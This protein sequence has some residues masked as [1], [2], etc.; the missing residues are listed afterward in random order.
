MIAEYEARLQR[1]RDSHEKVVNENVKLNAELRATERELSE[2]KS[3]SRKQ[4]LELTACSDKIYSLTV[5]S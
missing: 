3:K 2:Y 5:S 1:E 4:E